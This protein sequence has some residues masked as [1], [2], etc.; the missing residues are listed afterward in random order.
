[1]NFDIST[2]LKLFPLPSLDNPVPHHYE[3]QIDGAA[4]L[5][6]S[7]VFAKD[8]GANNKA[9][10]TVKYAGGIIVVST[11]HV[12]DTHHLPETIKVNGADVDGDEVRFHSGLKFGL[13]PAPWVA[14]S[15]RTVEAGKPHRYDVRAYIDLG[16]LGL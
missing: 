11:Y 14:F 2:L 5:V 9:T 13:P 16:F 10:L 8:L 3:G 6:E 15:F 12:F 4:H 7:V 1:M